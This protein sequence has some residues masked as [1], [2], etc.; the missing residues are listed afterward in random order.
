MPINP[1]V[2]VALAVVKLY[3]FSRHFG[4]TVLPLHPV[5]AAT[6]AMSNLLSSKALT[7]LI[8]DLI[9]RRPKNVV[10]CTIS[11]CPLSAFGILYSRVLT[12]V[13]PDS[14]RTAHR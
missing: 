4:V 8:V 10:G 14:V 11:T 12:T 6:A 5:T 9:A 13:S 7:L 2:C 1:T 3:R